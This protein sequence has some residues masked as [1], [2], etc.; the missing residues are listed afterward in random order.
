MSAPADR[1]TDRRVLLALQGLALGLPLLAHDVPWLLWPACLLAV[2]LLA[3]TTH[4][5]RRRSASPYAP[6]VAWLGAFVGLALATTVPLP[7]R[8]L[9]LLAPATAELYGRALPGWPDA[10]G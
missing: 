3:L 4:E 9:H 10:G 7:P 5:R 6:G 1:V 8:L 2:G